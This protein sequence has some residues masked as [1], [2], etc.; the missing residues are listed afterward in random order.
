MRE[1]IE[2]PAGKLHAS[3]TLDLEQLALVETICVGAHAVERAGIQAGMRLLVLGAGPIGLGVA[4]VAR[5]RGAEVTLADVNAS[6]LAFARDHA[7]FSRTLVVERDGLEAAVRDAFGG[8]LPSVVFDATGNARSMESAFGL[9][10][11]AGT[12]VFVGLVQAPISFHD[13]DLHRRELTLL[14]SRNALPADFVH[15]IGAMETGRI[16]VRPWI[17]HR[18]PLDEVPTQF[19]AWAEPSS[20]V[21]KAV[22]EV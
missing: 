20:G 11:H 13:P 3:A 18:S 21:V 16:D 10:G 9:V 19:A 15:V 6:R 12:L 4:E 7:G 17:T 14:A 8:E 22:I 2:V 1:L 5:G